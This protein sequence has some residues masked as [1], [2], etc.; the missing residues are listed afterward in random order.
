MER[1]ITVGLPVCGEVDV[2]R[3]LPLMNHPRFQA[4]GRR[5]QLG[6][7]QLVF[8]NAHHT[9]LEHSLGVFELTR[10]RMDRWIRSGFVSEEAAWDACLYGLLHDIGHGPYSHV[11][12]ALCEHGHKAQGLR[13]LEELTDGIVACGSTVAALQCYFTG[14]NPL[15][16]AVGHHP[17]GTDKLDYLERDSLHTL[18]RV[19]IPAQRVIAWTDWRANRLVV[20]GE[21]VYEVLQLQVAYFDMFL[22]V[23]RR[24]A[25][26]IIDRFFQKM[27]AQVMEQPETGEPLTESELW[28]MTDPELDARLLQQVPAMYQRVLTRQ[29]PRTVL[30]LRPT[31]ME[32]L[33]RGV[34]F[35]PK[36]LGVSELL[37]AQFDRFYCPR[38]CQTLERALAGS[39]GVDERSVLV[40]PVVLAS[41]FTPKEIWVDYGAGS[42]RRVR[43][44]WPHHF[45]SLAERARSY[46]AVRVCVHEEIWQRVRDQARELFE[47]LCAMA[48]ER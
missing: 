21:I 17:L 20:H 37:L 35:T 27:I 9:R 46:L 26:L 23:Y 25:S 16:T 45:A 33:E 5:N 11:V 41:R 42:L 2:T 7:I 39:L 12:E 18:A 22:R 24:R 36:V 34:E 48:V 30:T 14:E 15:Y 44:T 1:R 28:R 31:G 29:L 4:L 38:A 19:G 6:A 32:Y 47:L 13:I 43:D 40:L 3:I 8:P 10:R